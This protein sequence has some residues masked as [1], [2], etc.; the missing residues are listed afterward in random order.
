MT[1]II[2]NPDGTIKSFAESNEGAVLEPG[3]ACTESPLSFQEVAALFE[4][5][6]NGQT[7]QTVYAHVG[8]PAVEVTVRAPGQTTV[9][10]GVNGTAQTV[11][12]TNGAGTLTLPT[13]APIAYAL[14]P[15][16]RHKFC[17]AGAGSL[18]IIVS[19]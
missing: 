18:C 16:D 13:T 17:I 5:S 10:V 3:E 19:G 11:Q 2:F 8:D 12:L 9:E 14:A 1:Y 15:A 7:C 6:H 4:L